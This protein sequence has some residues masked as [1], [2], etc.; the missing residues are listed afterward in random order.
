MD[1]L[2]LDLRTELT[3]SFRQAV[4]WKVTDEELYIA[5]HQIPERFQQILAMYF[6]LLGHRVRTSEEIGQILVNRING[7]TVSAGRVTNLKTEGI[8]RLRTRLEINRAVK[9]PCGIP[10]ILD[11]WDVS[12]RCRYDLRRLGG[13]TLE[14]VLSISPWRSLQHKSR[15]ELIAYL[16]KY[17]LLDLTNFPKA[18]RVLALA[19]A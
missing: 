2:Q 8:Y 14:T 5:L 9:L 6:G 18:A 1:G 17:P 3:D 19:P 10:V 16:R 11:Y 7:K 4:Q 13:H 12:V 15:K